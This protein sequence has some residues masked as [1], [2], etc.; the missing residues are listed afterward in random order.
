MS[1]LPRRA[2]AKGSMVTIVGVVKLLVMLGRPGMTQEVSL[3]RMSWISLSRVV[4]D[5][6]G[7][8]CGSFSCGGRSCGDGCDGGGVTVWGGT[9]FCR[10]NEP[11]EPVF[12]LFWN[13]LAWSVGGVAARGR[14]RSTMPLLFYG[15]TVGCDFVGCGSVDFGV[16]F[17]TRLGPGSLCVKETSVS[18]AGGG[19]G[20]VGESFGK[21]VIPMRARISS[22]MIL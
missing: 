3:L 1:A 2:S 8:G 4:V 14:F 16:G 22:Y 21:D 18:W 10:D 7:G 20:Q 11:V 15:A 12:A 13:T 9:L 6:S 17:L 5:V 19:R